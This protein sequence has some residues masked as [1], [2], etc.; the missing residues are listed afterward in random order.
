[1]RSPGGLCSRWACRRITRWDFS[2]STASDAGHLHVAVRV[3]L[4]AAPDRANS[5]CRWHVSVVLQASPLADR[6]A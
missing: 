2:S 4:V 6:R 3:H 5:R 1:M